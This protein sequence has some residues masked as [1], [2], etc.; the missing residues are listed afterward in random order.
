MK[1]I[2]ATPYLTDPVT[3]KRLQIKLSSNGHQI[4]IDAKGY[5]DFT[6]KKGRGTPAIVEWNDGKLRIVAWGDINQEDPTDIVDL[7]NAKE[8]KRG[9]GTPA[10]IGAMAAKLDDDRARAADLAY[11]TA[12][13]SVSVID[14]G[15]WQTDGPNRLIRAFYYENESDPEN[16]KVASFIV[17]FKPGTAEVAEAYENV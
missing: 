3:G 13:L 1:G 2:V 14:S 4:A 11:E 7:S 8:S 16:S 5:G 15:G 12:D 17:D 6:S 9:K 10:K